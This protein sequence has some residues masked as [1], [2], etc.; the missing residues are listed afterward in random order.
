[1]QTCFRFVFISKLTDFLNSTKIKVDLVKYEKL[2]HLNFVM[3]NASKGMIN[4][5]LYRKSI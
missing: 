4:N 3:L 1:M 2:K 5:P